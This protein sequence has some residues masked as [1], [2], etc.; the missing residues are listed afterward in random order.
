ML[1][2]VNGLLKRD[3]LIELLGLGT[4]ENIA[5]A[6]AKVNEAGDVELRLITDAPETLYD[7]P[8][9]SAYGE[10]PRIDILNRLK[11]PTDPMWKSKEIKV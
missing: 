4:V 11:K 8:R 9:F 5:I 6:E 2:Q 1:Y 7:I 3:E 10:A